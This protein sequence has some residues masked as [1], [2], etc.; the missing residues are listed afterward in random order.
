MAAA[1]DRGQ[2]QHRRPAG[3][4]GRPAGGQHDRRQQHRRDGQAGVAGEVREEISVERAG[5]EPAARMGGVGERREQREHHRRAADRD[6]DPPLPAGDVATAAVRKQPAAG[7]AARREQRA[8]ED[9]AAEQDQ[10]AVEHRIEQRAPPAAGG[11][12]AGRRGLGWARHGRPY[13]ERVRALGGVTVV[14]G[15][16]VPPQL[17]DPAPE[18]VKRPQHESRRA[19]AR[20]GRGH[21]DAAGRRQRQ[22]AQRA[23]Q[24]LAERGR[25]RRRRRGEARPRQRARRDQER[26]RGRRRRDDQQADQQADQQSG[27]GAQRGHVT[28]RSA[29]PASPRHGGPARCSS[30]CRCRP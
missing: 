2:R 16:R 3:A 21:G 8:A 20:D 29:F 1:G 24:R 10:R 4:A 15:D 30:T 28:A 25:D 12:R 6:R 9:A 13:P 7:L 17:V 27:A 18:T 23:V 26:V 22:R 14:G 5:A 19:V 11:E